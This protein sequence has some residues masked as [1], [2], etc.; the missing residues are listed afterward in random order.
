MEE[1]ISRY[2]SAGGA[3]G[4][5]REWPEVGEVASVSSAPRDNAGI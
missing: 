2:C 1:I 5:E 4:F 3:S